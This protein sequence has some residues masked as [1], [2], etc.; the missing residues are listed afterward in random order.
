[1]RQ[2]TL[3]LPYYLNPGMLERHYAGLRNLPR[4]I[5]ENLALIVVDDGSPHAPATPPRYGI[6]IPISIFRMRKDVRWN[7]DACRNLAVAQ[8]KTDWVLLTDIDHLTPASLLQEVVFGKLRED[9]IYMFERVSEPEMEPYKPHPNS[10]L[11]TRAM[12]DV[13]GGYDERYAGMYGTDGMFRGRAAAAAPIKRLDRALVRVPRSVT[14]DAS[15]TTY[16]RKELQDAVMKTE[17]AAAIKAS[18]D[19]TPHRG[20][21]EWDRVYP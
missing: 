21:F 9:T 17:I 14:P 8:A 16:I 18:G 10:W 19:F 12:Y 13:V 7:Q 11:M 3:C 6:G 20:L 2:V 1:M 15:T 4:N 5:K